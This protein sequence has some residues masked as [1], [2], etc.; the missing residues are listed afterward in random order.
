[1]KDTILS[2]L[3]RFGIHKWSENHGGIKVCVRDE[4]CKARTYGFTGTMRKIEFEKELYDEYQKYTESKNG[5]EK[6]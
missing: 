2:L 4:C 1:M 6:L 5:N 3:C